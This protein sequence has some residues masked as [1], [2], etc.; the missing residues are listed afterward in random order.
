VEEKRKY[1]DKK[2]LSSRCREC[3]E[4]NCL[5][6]DTHLKE[7]PESFTN[8]NPEKKEEQPDG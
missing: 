4:P 7:N 1:Q 3:E 2:N 6:C 5:R 8:L